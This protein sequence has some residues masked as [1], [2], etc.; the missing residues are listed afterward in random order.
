MLHIGGY[1]TRFYG[2]IQKELENSSL[3]CYHIPLHSK[4]DLKAAR[5]QHWVSNCMSYPN[6]LLYFIIPIT[7]MLTSKLTEI[8]LNITQ[9]Q[10]QDW[11][12]HLLDFSPLHP[13][14]LRI[15]RNSSWETWMNLFLLKWSWLR[16]WKKTKRPK[17]LIINLLCLGNPILIK[18]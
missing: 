15:W 5:N 7:Q 10:Y 2:R 9:K 16:F 3:L 14:V 11:K 18:V 1:S 17:W 12:S 6:N 13:N 8:T 4:P